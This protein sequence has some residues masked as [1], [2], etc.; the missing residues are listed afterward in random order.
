MIETSTTTAD[1]GSPVWHGTETDIKRLVELVEILQAEASEKVRRRLSE[2]QQR[3]DEENDERVLL[4]ADAIATGIS[5]RGGDP[6][7]FAEPKFLLKEVENYRRM[8]IDSSSSEARAVRDLDLKMTVRHKSWN[9]ERTGRPDVLLEKL[10]DRETVMIKLEFG[11]SWERSSHYLA[12][13][14]GGSGC[15][16]QLRGSLPWVSSAMG[17]LKVELGKQG[18]RLGFLYNS[19]LLAAIGFIAGISL[20]AI[21]LQNLADPLDFV[22]VAV[23]GGVAGGM[24]LPSL[25]ERWFPRFEITRSSKQRTRALIGVGVTIV[26]GILVNLISKSIGI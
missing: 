22:W 19:Y 6:G 25:F 1:F 8:A 3:A 4:M 11:S 21:L 2:A 13:D 20:C 9:E 18:S 17:Q 12:V 24:A 7:S 15:R 16:V 10:D 5:S 23:A 14:L 26:L